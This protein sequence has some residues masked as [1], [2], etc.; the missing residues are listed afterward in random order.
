MR[1]LGAPETTGAVAFRRGARWGLWETRLAGAALVG[2]VLAGQGCSGAYESAVRADF[3]RHRAPRITA[4]GDTESASLGPELNGYLAYAAERSPELKAS[5]ERWRAS[6]HRISP[7]RTM[8]DPML[9]FGVYVWNSGDNIGLT[10]ARVGLRQ[11]LPWPAQLT[12]GADAASAEARAQQR[13]FE[14][15]LLEVRARVAAGYYQLWLLRRMRAIEREH[16]EI[17]RGLSEAALGQLSVGQASLADQQ[18]IDLTMARLADALAAL[19]EQERAE[20]ARLRAVVGAPP[21]AVAETADREPPVALPE[22]S[23]ASLRQAAQEHPGIETFVLMGEAAEAMARAERVERYPGFVLGVEWMRMPGAH[24]ESAI[25]PSV[26]VRL[27]I[28]QGRYAEAIRAAEAEAS[29]QV[30]EGRA[31]VQRAQAEL[32]DALTRVRDSKRRIEL[33]EHTLLPQALAAYESVL[34]AYA[35]G[36]ATV[37]ASLLAQRDLIELRLSLEQARADH[38]MAWA[39]L[40]RIVGRPVRREPQGQGNRE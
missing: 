32:T 28:W 9:E 20:A 26:G 22:E 24:A 2:T 3:N 25:M 37:A 27:P 19:D 4:D 31:A 16:L 12:A 29:A 14:A 15:Q 6:V 34:G 35:T 5:Y 40:E 23:E 38:A 1:H 33:H 7:A 8:P 21:D 10:P 39:E 11:E 36:R 13:S 17:L 30:S 18:Q